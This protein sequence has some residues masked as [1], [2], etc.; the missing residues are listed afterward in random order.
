MM[1]MFDQ[2]SSLDSFSKK[3]LEMFISLVYTSVQCVLR[4]IMTLHPVYQKFIVSVCICLVS[5]DSFGQVLSSVSALRV[6][7]SADS[8]VVKQVPADTTVKVLKRQGFFLEVEVAGAKGWVKASEVSM[9]KSPGGGLSNLDTG[10]TGKGNIVSTSA[11]RG[12]SAKDLIAAK[13]NY[14]QVDELKKLGTP[15]KASEDFAAQGGL[16]N[17]KLTLLSAADTPAS[18]KKVNN[19]PRRPTG[20]K[21]D[22]EDEDE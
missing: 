15:S 14:Q 6:E 20:R 9:T 3:A 4:V 16:Q 12:L 11:A 1:G 10:R 5:S 2:W 8:K 19:T 7:P 22:E 21:K 18:A 17:R 13:P